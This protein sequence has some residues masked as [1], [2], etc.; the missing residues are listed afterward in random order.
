M[1]LTHFC[2]LLSKRLFYCTLIGLQSY[3]FDIVNSAAELLTIEF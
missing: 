1:L 2:L 3:G